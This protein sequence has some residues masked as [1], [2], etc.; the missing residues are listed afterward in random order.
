MDNGGLCVMMGFLMDQLLMLSASS[1]DTRGVQDTH[2]QC[3]FIVQIN[4]LVII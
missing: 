2:H 1:W 4:G 3:E